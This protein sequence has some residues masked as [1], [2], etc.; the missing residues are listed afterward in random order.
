MHI[1]GKGGE[2]WPEAGVIPILPGFEAEGVS[3]RI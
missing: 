1:E 3:A 2:S